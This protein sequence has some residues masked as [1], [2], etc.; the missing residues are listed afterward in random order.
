MIFMQKK[1]VENREDSFQRYVPH[2]HFYSPLPSKEDEEKYCANKPVDV[3]SS[4]RLNI[5][6][7][8]SLCH[9]M[10]KFYNPERFAKTER[11]LG[12]NGNTRYYYENKFFSYGDGIILNMFLRKTQPKRIVEVGCGFSSAM[13]LDTCDMFSELGDVDFTFIEPEPERRLLK[14]VNEREINLIKS[15]LQDLEPDLIYNSLEA[16]DLLFID[17]SHVVKLNSDVMFIFDRILPNLKKGVYVHFH[18]VVYP[19]VYP[20][21]WVREGRFWNEAF[22]LKQFLAYNDSWK[23]V[24]WPVMLHQKNLIQD[25]FPI[26]NKDVG[27]SLY[28]QKIR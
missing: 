10:K 16:G 21:C 26:L 3:D 20:D 22:F 19:F 5:D 17:S 6:E 9:E 13:M 18:D 7:Q 24:L 1:C 12:K 25:I 2:G 23:I 14:L 27:G 8:L 11:G 28:L 15:N 4:I